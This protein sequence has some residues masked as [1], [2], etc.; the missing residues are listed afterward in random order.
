MFGRVSS[1]EGEQYVPKFFGLCANQR[2]A[3]SALLST[4]FTCLFVAFALCAAAAAMSVVGWMQWL[5]DDVTIAQNYWNGLPQSTINSI[6]QQV[7]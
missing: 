4:A 6:Q 7:P 1:K 3:T 2:K 5:Q